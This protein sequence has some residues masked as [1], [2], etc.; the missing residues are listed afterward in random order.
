MHLKALLVVVKISMLSIVNS[1]IYFK[2]VHNYQI[3][4]EYCS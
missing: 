4:A 2:L 1:K 3:K